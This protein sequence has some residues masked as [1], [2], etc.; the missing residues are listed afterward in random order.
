M[1]P[2]PWPTIIR[3]LTS[4]GLTQPEI[5]QLCGCGQSTISDLVRGSTTDPRTSTG[6]ALLALARERGIYAADWPSLGQGAQAADEQEVQRA[7]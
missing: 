3:G 1:S 2:I 6:L 7:A 5:A 4:A